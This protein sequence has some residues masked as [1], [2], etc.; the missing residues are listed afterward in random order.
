M[1]PAGCELFPISDLDALHAAIEK[2]LSTGSPRLSHE[3]GGD[4]NVKAVV[5][6]YLETLGLD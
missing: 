4:Q 5:D 2:R 1:R 3:A 6:L